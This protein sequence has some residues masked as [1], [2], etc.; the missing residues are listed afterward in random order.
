MATFTQDFTNLREACDQGREDRHQ[1][2]GKMRAEVKQLAEE[3]QDDM[4]GFRVQH[5][6]T[7]DEVKQL[8][9]ETQDDMARFRAEHEAM[10]DQ[11]RSELADFAGD[12]NAGGR[13]FRGA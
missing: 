13:I 9:E 2:Y 7:R 3:T 6:R 12:L 8:A 1:F 10:G 5:E 4:A 11:L